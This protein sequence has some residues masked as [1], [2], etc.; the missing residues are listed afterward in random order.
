VLHRHRLIFV[1]L[2]A[3]LIAACEKLAPL[4][5]DCPDVSGM[6]EGRSAQCG[7]SE[8]SRPFSV[9]QDGSS[10]MIQFYLATDCVNGWLHEDRSASMDEFGCSVRPGDL[11][12]S[13]E[14]RFEL[15]EP[16]TFRGKSCSRSYDNWTH[17][18]GDEKCSEVCWQ[19]VAPITSDGGQ[20]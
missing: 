2:T 15:G 11:E 16:I 1:L 4:C 6:Y 12:T 18:W 3:L 19:R 14:G 7:P 9:K 10:L 8:P 20:P 13:L 5:H 17:E